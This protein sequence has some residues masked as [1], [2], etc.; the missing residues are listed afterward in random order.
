M[1][2]G[3]GTDGIMKKED[4]WGWGV[5]WESGAEKEIIFH[6]KSRIDT[7]EEI[8][9]FKEKESQERTGRDS[10]ICCRTPIGHEHDS[11]CLSP[12][13]RSQF[14]MNEQMFISM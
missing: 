6:M 5:D 10:S 4:R 9:E 11:R 2:D 1:D 14:S 12:G 13:V 3:Q 7:T 8:H